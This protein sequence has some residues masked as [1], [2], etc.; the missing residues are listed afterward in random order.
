MP[1]KRRIRDNASEELLVIRPKFNQEISCRSRK[2]KILVHN[3]AMERGLC[4]SW[5]QGEGARVGR[6]SKGCTYVFVARLLLQKSILLLGDFCKVSNEM[7]VVIM[8][9]CFIFPPLW[10]VLSLPFH[11]FSRIP[12]LKFICHCISHLYFIIVLSLVIVVPWDRSYLEVSLCFV[13]QFTKNEFSLQNF[14]SC[15]K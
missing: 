1:S 8:I 14:F 2:I 13:I 3:K 11:R 4:V 15:C 5:R 6:R 10:F 9:I 7:A 12:T